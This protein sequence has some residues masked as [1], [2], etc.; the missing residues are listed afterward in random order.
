MSRPDTSFHRLRI[1]L[2]PL[3]LLSLLCFFLPSPGFAGA[4]GYKVVAVQKNAWVTRKDASVKANIS[5]GDSIRTDS[6]ER[7]QLAA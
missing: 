3:F 1:P 5:A 7:L 4:D 6:S 2:K